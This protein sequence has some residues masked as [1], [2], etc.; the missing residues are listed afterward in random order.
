MY[1]LYIHVIIFNTDRC[2]KSSMQHYTHYKCV[3]LHLLIRFFFSRLNSYSRIWKY[4]FL[5]FCSL[6]LT[7]YKQWNI[8]I[9][10]ENC[11]SCI[12][13]YDININVYFIH[14]E[15]YILYL[16]T[17]LWKKPHKLFSIPN[18]LS[19]KTLKYFRNFHGNILY[20]RQTFCKLFSCSNTYY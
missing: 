14:Y 20:R 12:P 17:P 4:E 11:A 7:S 18:K 2:S 16:L 3:L 15:F 5:I 6:S 13:I 19:N 10:I 8:V 9:I 1:I